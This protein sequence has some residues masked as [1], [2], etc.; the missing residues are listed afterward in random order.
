M[1]GT[2]IADGGAQ[3]NASD[4][5]NSQQTQDAE[6]RALVEEVLKMQTTL[7]GKQELFFFFLF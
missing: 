5:S 1:E 6:K 2:R 4:G 7:D 3:V